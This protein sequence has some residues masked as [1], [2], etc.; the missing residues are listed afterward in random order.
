[1]N[2]VLGGCCARRKSHFYVIDNFMV[3]LYNV[4]IKSTHLSDV[5]GFSTN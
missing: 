3:L 2:E 5:S 1:M 4:D